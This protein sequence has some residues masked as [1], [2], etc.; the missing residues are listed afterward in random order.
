MSWSSVTASILKKWVLRLEPVPDTGLVCSGTHALIKKYVHMKEWTVIHE[1]L[2]LHRSQ[3]SQTQVLFIFEL[4]GIHSQ[5]NSDFYTWPGPQSLGERSYFPSKSEKPT[6]LSTDPWK[7]KQVSVSHHLLGWGSSAYLATLIWLFLPHKSTEWGSTLATK[8]YRLDER[9]FLLSII[10]FLPYESPA[11]F[12]DPLTHKRQGSPFSFCWNLI[13]DGGTHL[14]CSQH[15][16]LSWN[17]QRRRRCWSEAATNWHLQTVHSKQKQRSFYIPGWLLPG[18]SPDFQIPFQT[19]W[20]IGWG[21]KQGQRGKRREGWEWRK[22]G[23]FP[24]LIFSLPS[25]CFISSVWRGK[26]FSIESPGQFCVIFHFIAYFSCQLWQ[27]LLSPSLP[28]SPVAF[29]PWHQFRILPHPIP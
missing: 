4:W 12:S 22:T 29:L 16:M 2:P 3:L 19:G 1:A 5:K 20:Q 27:Q 23:H 8:R 24:R 9:Y 7:A 28:A 13:H 18:L 11:A 10:K 21:L 26:K 14:S 25:P 6:Q 15:K 17:E